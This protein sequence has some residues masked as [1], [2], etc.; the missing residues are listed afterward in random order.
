M[1]GGREVLR[2]VLWILLASLTALALLLFTAIFDPDLTSQPKPLTRYDEAVTAIR[3]VL[4]LEAEEQPLIEHGG[5]LAVLTGART[6]VAV[7]IFHGY[8]GTP[9]GFRLIAQAYHDHGCNV[10]VP[11]M[12]HHGLADKMTD[13]FSQ[14][15]SEELRGFADEAIDIGAGLGG[16]VLV[17]GLSGGGALATWAAVERPEVDRSVLI[18]PLLSPG[19]YWSWQVPPMVRALRLSPVDGYAWWEPE[20][21]ADN[22]AGM[23]Y[24]RYSLKG[25][26]AFLGLRLWIEPKPSGT[27]SGSVLLIRNAGDPSVDHDFNEALVR[28]LV[29]AEL[30]EVYQVPADAQLPRDFVCPDPESGP[31]TQISEAYRQLSAALGIPMPNPLTSR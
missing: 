3:Q 8:T 18:S 14:L 7:V 2:R 28:R 30:V 9:Y 31:D 25:I 6:P 1:A 10:W 16:E 23:L 21:G 27:V 12:P 26:A 11:R 22:V 29:P 5:S 15:T 4:F 19:G 24:P 13:E 20:R 17:I